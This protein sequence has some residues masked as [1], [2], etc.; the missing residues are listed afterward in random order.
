LILLN[1]ESPLDSTEI[2]P[3]HPKGNQSWIFIGRTDAEAGTRIL[4]PPDAKNWLIW[5]DSDAGK[6]WR[7]E[8]KGTTEDEMVGWHYQLSGH[9]FEQALG[10]GDGQGSHWILSSNL[11]SYLCGC[12]F[13]PHFSVRLHC[14]H[15][16]IIELD[17]F[18]K[19]YIPSWDPLDQISRSVMSD[20]L[21]PHELQHARPPCP[22]PTPGV[23]WD[24]HPSSCDAIQPSHP[25]S[26]P[27]P[28]APNPSQHQ[29]IP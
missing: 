21:W 7:Q 13:N 23:H 26:S 11:Q 22:S 1:C 14:I 3:V 28:L 29:R 25:L 15:F 17:Y 27:S 2:Q 18:V 8:E 4:W 20:S 5:K 19:V 10:V 6:D 12:L 16:F 24:S 9:E